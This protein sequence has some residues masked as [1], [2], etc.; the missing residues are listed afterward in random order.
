MIRLG[1]TNMSGV[2]KDAL[3]LISVSSQKKYRDI[4]IKNKHLFIGLEDKPLISIIIPFVSFTYLLKRLILSILSSRGID[5]NK[6]I[7]IIL[8]CNSENVDL[9]KIL[10]NILDF[11]TSNF[12][13][14]LLKYTE[15]KGP[16]PA[17]CYGAKN[18][19]ADYILF[20]ASDTYLDE[21]CLSKFINALNP[22][23]H[24]YLGNY[25]GNKVQK[26]IPYLESLIDNDR[27]INEHKIDFR[28]FGC[29]KKVFL[30]ILEKHYLNKFCSDMELNFVVKNCDYKIIFLPTAIV[31]NEYPQNIFEAVGRKIKH[32]IGC[33]RIFKNKKLSPCK[34]LFKSSLDSFSYFSYFSFIV[35]FRGLSFIKKI[36][37]FILVLAF[38]S[39]LILGYIMPLKFIKRYYT[40]YFDEK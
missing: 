33:G 36:K 20:L 25:S 35:K 34:M 37:F 31:F 1:K 2:N 29:A 18:T 17:W 9:G 22:E 14:T 23:I 6:I 8:I 26:G 21:F 5:Q 12:F 40:F 4:I 10:A 11:Q 32:G 7:E 24:F 38:L 3:D 16:S 28:A 13:F 39:G 30:K 19:K 15:I 27:F